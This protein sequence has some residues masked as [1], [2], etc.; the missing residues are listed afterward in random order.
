MNDTLPP[1]YAEPSDEPRLLIVGMDLANAID[2]V[3]S[4]SLNALTPSIIAQHQPDVILFALFSP[5]QDAIS[6]IERL[7]LIGYGGHI[8]V[9]CPVLPK[10]ALV[11]AEL[12]ALGPGLRLSVIVAGSG[13]HTSGLSRL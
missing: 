3:A 11:E 1:A 2:G 12:R 10:P 6:V 13:D 9:I 5:M 4:I 8:R 7:E